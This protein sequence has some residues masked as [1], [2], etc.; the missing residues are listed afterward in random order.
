MGG[1]GAGAGWALGAV[2]CVAFSA[3][4][5]ADPIGSSKAGVTMQHC[6]EWER[7]AQPFSTGVE[8]LLAEVVPQKSFPKGDKEQQ[9]PSGIALSFWETKTFILEGVS[10]WGTKALTIS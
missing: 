5:S 1:H 2:G 3:K 4:A 8:E 10:G 6:T 7:G 9:L